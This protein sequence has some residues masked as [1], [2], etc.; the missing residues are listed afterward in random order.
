[1][2]ERVARN[3]AMFREA[4]EE[5]RAMARR[6]GMEGLLPA[7]CE[8]ADPACTELVQL[9][10]QE[11]EAVR[12]NSTWFINLRGHQANAQGWVRVLSENSRFV[13]VEKVGEAGE[14]AAQLDPRSSSD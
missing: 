11:Y 5:I 7:L 9:T 4:N 2:A 14:I 6:S 1:M 12:S 3:D 13:L 8:C 10:P